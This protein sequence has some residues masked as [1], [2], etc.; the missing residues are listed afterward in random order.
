M[1]KNNKIKISIDN[2]DYFGWTEI[3]KK[4]GISDSLLRARV[5]KLGWSI[6]DAIKPVGKIKKHN[7]SIF[8]EEP[9][10]QTKKSLLI[11]LL[12][13]HVLAKQL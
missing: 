10:I 11:V 5:N 2:K 6:S 4:V 3:S 12:M 13:S 7:K 1:R 8:L 9:N